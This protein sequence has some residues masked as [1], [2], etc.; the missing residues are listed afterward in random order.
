MLKDKCRSLGDVYT[1][2]IMMLKSMVP[3]LSAF[4]ADC[5]LPVL[6]KTFSTAEIQL[7]L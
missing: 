5:L 4:G 7:P 2:C 6:S 1:K 3:T